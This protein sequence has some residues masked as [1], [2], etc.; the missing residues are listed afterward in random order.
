MLRKP[1]TLPSE[2]WS[3]I[4]ARV[5]FPRRLTQTSK[6]FHALSKSAHTRALYLATQLNVRSVLTQVWHDPRYQRLLLN[7]DVIDVLMSWGAPLPRLIVRSAAKMFANEG[8][9]EERWASATLLWKIVTLGVAAYG[10]DVCGG[11][12]DKALFSKFLRILPCT[13][14]QY[15]NHVTLFTAYKYCPVFHEMGTREKVSL[16]TALIL[17]SPYKDNLVGVLKGNGFDVESFLRLSNTR[18]VA[19]TFG[20]SRNSHYLEIYRH[21]AALDPALPEILLERVFLHTLTHPL[22]TVLSR[23]LAVFGVAA[24]RKRALRLL[25]NQPL[26]SICYELPTALSNLTTH[27]LASDQ[28]VLQVLLHYINLRK[29]F[30]KDDPVFI[31]VQNHVKSSSE[32]APAILGAIFAAIL[33]RTQTLKATE[34]S[35]IDMIENYVTNGVGIEPTNIKFF[36]EIPKM[37]PLLIRL[38][39]MF[40]T[41]AAEKI[42]MGLDEAEC[43]VWIKGITDAISSCGECHTCLHLY[44]LPDFMA[45]PLHHIS[46]N[47]SN[48]ER[49]VAKSQIK[50]DAR[51][52]AVV[53]FKELLSQLEHVREGHK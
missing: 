1:P 39:E 6:S 25:R 53:K 5:P 24:M 9:E 2:L 26:K 19:C 14:K 20:D 18:V 16:A 40:V 30:S 35:L 17:K 4:L 21:G 7:V 3:D 12:D 45:W 31:W 42:Q 32:I 22:D 38:L 11:E 48:T 8:C 50:K 15:E 27:L 36:A 43:K 44:S 41:K 52:K 51:E 10:E 33:N 28:D 29:P 47:S 34:S 49:V 13:L 23:L 46:L 37:E